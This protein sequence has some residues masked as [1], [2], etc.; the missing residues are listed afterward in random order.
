MIKGLGKL[1]PKTV[2]SI[3]VTP[4]SCS[5]VLATTTGSSS[6]PQTTSVPEP[7]TNL[8]VG[9]LVRALFVLWV[10]VA[11]TQ[12]GLALASQDP[13]DPHSRPPLSTATPE[14]PAAPK[15]FLY[16]GNHVGLMLGPVFSGLDRA[17]PGLD[18]NGTGLR[19]GGRISAITQFID[20]GV[21][22]QHVE[23][24]GSAASLSRTELGVRVG[25]HPAFPFVVFNSWINDVISGV[26]LYVGASVGRLALQGQQAV[27]AVGLDGTSAVQ[28]RP[29]A[30][31]GV[32]ADLPV[33][34]RHRPNGWWLTLR[35]ELRWTGF[36]S[37]APRH[38]LDDSMVGVLLGYRSYNNSWARWSRPF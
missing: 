30:L 24:G 36:G 38:N 8:G 25:S 13:V 14:E 21:D 10:I 33:S 32:G 37:T 17:L 20:G 11:A 3:R 28:W 35:Y 16:D 27:A 12:P 6:V 4:G 1:A 34:P 18:R 15:D 23:H 26:H 19:L 2:N 22:L 29:S 31:V 9:V 7:G 5:R